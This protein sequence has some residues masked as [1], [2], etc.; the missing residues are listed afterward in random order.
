[1][2][3]FP[4]DFIHLKNFKLA[5]MASSLFKKS[6]RLQFPRTDT[7]ISELLLCID[8]KLLSLFVVNADEIFV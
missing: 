3:Q 5:E 1:V 4:C 2:S 7:N 8:T 6:H